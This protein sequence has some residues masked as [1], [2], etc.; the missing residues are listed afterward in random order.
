MSCSTHRCKRM[1]Y[2]ILQP[3][4]VYVVVWQQTVVG[5]IYSTLHNITEPVYL[6]VTRNTVGKTVT[7]CVASYQKLLTFLLTA[8]FALH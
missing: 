6:S 8:C 4:A 3:Q 2:A 7:P 1:Q 5:N